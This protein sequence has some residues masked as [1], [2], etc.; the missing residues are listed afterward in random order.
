MAI[1]S[2]LAIP[3][4]GAANDLEAQLAALPGCEVTRAVNREVF[5]LVTE[6]AEEEEEAALQE[7]FKRLPGLA[8]LILTFGEL[9]RENR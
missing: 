2:Y 6:T 9:D 5:L 3:R 7:A 8:A 1:C 4:N